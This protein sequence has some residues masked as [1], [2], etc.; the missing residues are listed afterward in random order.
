M[1]IFGGAAPLVMSW[2]IYW[3]H[4]IL[5]PAIYYMA[6]GCVCLLSIRMLPSHQ[7]EAALIER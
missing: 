4:N 2:L 3:S 5:S 6:G 1:A 7:V